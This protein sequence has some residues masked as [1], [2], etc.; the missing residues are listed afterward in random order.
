MLVL[1]IIQGALK[2]NGSHSLMHK[3]PTQWIYY[4]PSSCHKTTFWNLP[5]WFQDWRL[6]WDGPPLHQLEQ[7]FPTVFLE[8]YHHI[9]IHCNPNK[10]HLFQRLVLIE[11][12]I[13]RIRNADLGLKWISQDSISPGTGLGTT[14]KE[15]LPFL[16]V[17]SDWTFC[18]L[19]HHR[20][21]GPV[22]LDL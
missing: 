11:L 10:R 6:H 14:E 19:W 7:S 16:L 2:C 1:L 12:L 4:R 17:W 15:H 22:H 18:I 5:F 20:P 8:I 21:H 3:Q 13:S 9:G